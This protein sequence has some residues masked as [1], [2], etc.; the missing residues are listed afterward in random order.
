MTKKRFQMGLAIL[1]VLMV[2]TACRCQAPASADII[3]IWEEDQGTAGDTPCASF[4]FF[5]DG[6]FEAYNVPSGYFITFSGPPINSVT[7]FW[8]LD[9]PSKDL[10]TPR[11]IELTFNDSD[12]T[13]GFDSSFIIPGAWQGDVIYA[14]DF[15]DPI[16]FVKKTEA[17][18]R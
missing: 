10:L 14:R 5:A 18:C 6:H 17:E 3:G 4:E 1:G 13:R 8:K 12:E 7:G 11:Y 2:I 16:R 15:D 9:F